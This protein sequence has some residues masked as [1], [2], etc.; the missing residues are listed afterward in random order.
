MSPTSETPRPVEAGDTKKKDEGLRVCEHCLHLLHNRLEM[1]ESRNCRPPI[2]RYYDKIEQMKKDIAPDAKMY[3]KIVDRLNEGDP[4][5]TLA[6]AS[7]L[8]GKIGKIAELIDAYSKSILALP[9][10]NGSREMALKEAIRLGCIKYIKDELLSLSPLPQAEKIKELQTRRMQETAM[11]IERERRLAME[12]IEKYE[13]V[14][15]NSQLPVSPAHMDR[16]ASGVKELPVLLS[17][18]SQLNIC[19][20]SDGRAVPGQLVRNAGGCEQLIK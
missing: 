10:P 18:M 9:C 2:T 20:L 3:T 14:D 7:A 1:Q 16:F 6:D 5:Y 15:A 13:L 19:L 12:A 4:I 17:V 8:R 11:R